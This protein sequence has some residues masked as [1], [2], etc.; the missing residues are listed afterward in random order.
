MFTLH[1]EDVTLYH[2]DVTLHHKEGS[3]IAPWG[4]VLHCTVRKDVYMALLW[5]MFTLHHYEECLITPEHA[6]QWGRKPNGGVMWTR[7]AWVNIYLQGIDSWKRGI[8]KGLLSLPVPSLIPI[9][10]TNFPD[11][12]FFFFYQYFILNVPH[13]QCRGY[14]EINGSLEG[15]RKMGRPARERDWDN[16]WQNYLY[17]HIIYDWMTTKIWFQKWKY[18]KQN[19][20]IIFSY[21]YI[22]FLQ[23]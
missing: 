10:L 20:V 14:V 21:V 15:E 23:T 18:C 4:R 5:R 13:Y 12:F 11:F 8:G 17:I 3:Y 7:P 22:F 1:H 2:E 19:N 16:G 9:L 6:P